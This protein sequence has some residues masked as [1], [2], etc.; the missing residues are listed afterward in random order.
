M[1][2][3][4]SLG[5]APGV[6]LA[7]IALPWLIVFPLT[8]IAGVIARAILLIAAFHGAGLV[9]GKLARR[10][11]G[12]VAPDVSPWMVIQWG[13]AAL[14]GA[15]GLAI[16]L[17]I[18]TLPTQAILV[19][20]AAA[21]H[22]AALSLRFAYCVKRVELAL[23]G[24]R[25]W[26]AP[27]LLLAA[28]G[29]L[30]LAGTS[31]VE[32]PQPFDDETHAFAQLQRVLDS[33]ALADP[34]GFPRRAQLGGQIALAALAAGAGDGL[35]RIAEALALV[36]ALG[37]A[38]SRIASREASS[39]LW[40]VLLVIAASALALQ[41]LHPLPIWTAVGLLIALYTMLSELD[42]PPALLPP[43]LGTP[44]IAPSV[45][46]QPALPLALT[47][48]ALITLRYELVPI[49]I[50]AVLYAWWGRP[51]DRRR[52]AVLAGGALAIVLPFVLAR[53]IA[54]HP[55]SDAARKL[56]AA[57]PQLALIVRALLAALIALPAIGVL[58]LALPESRAVRRAA[59][60]TTVGLA[61]LAAHLIV[62]G[63]YSMRM[64]WPIAIAFGVVLVIELART[65]WAGPAALITS[66]V[67]CVLIWEGR[68]APAR[69]R[70]SQRLAVAAANL[71]DVK[72]TAWPRG[73]S[74]D[75]YRPLLDAADPGTTIAVWVGQPEQL[76]YARHRII[77]L[78]GPAT[79]RLRVHRWVPTPPRL[80]SL[81]GELSADYLLVE[82]DD[83]H[84]RRI[85]TDVLYRVLCSAADTA[86]AI[87]LD[88]LEALARA[89]TVIAE[90]GGVRLIDLRR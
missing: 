38:L 25:T 56:I 55:V 10:G 12:A 16:S 23:A 18:G 5:L 7:A 33:G 78:R 17:G 59:L 71:D 47:A 70:W 80:A 75:P 11:H 44:P 1:S 39:A 45:L 74:L 90:Q 40:G 42:R 48:G 77:D 81:V 76:D 86:P 68:D 32:L 58:R 14:I 69:L 31:S 20:S 73:S 57:P 63:A 22:T 6:V 46:G 43:G 65:R 27:A 62:P 4:L 72:W 89:H 35:P 24:E 34:I 87:C 61:A 52:I 66:L 2:L 8:G 50:V 37:F 21:V 84:V 26:I 19:F 41:P 60:A 36:L 54:W 82:A 28:F 9:V 15:S 29:A 51:R 79:A 3:G 49:A 67:L 13:I 30:V 64:A 85:Q 83:A 88:S 53:T